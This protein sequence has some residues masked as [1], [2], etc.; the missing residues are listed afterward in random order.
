MNEINLDSEGE[1]TADV[2]E[3]IKYIRSLKMQEKVGL[4]MI[5]AG[6]KAIEENKK[7]GKSDTAFNFFD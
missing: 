5:T 4:L 1:K 6:L 2:I 7:S 3:F